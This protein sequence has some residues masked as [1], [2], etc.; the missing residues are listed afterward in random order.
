MH[1]GLATKFFPD[2]DDDHEPMAGVPDDVPLMIIASI[3]FSDQPQFEATDLPI[4]QIAIEIYTPASGGLYLGER[5]SP[6]GVKVKN[7]K[8]VAVGEE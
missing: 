7:M 1:R 5:F 2:S 8:K 4:S 6:A 3:T